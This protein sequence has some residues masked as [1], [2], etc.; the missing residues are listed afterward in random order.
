MCATL[1]RLVLVGIS[2]KTYALQTGGAA[3]SA[4]RSPTAT[5]WR[6][7]GA[8]S[9]GYSKL[10][11]EHYLPMAFVQA[12]ILAS[13]ADI[14]TQ[15]MERHPAPT[16]PLAE[17][18]VPYLQQLHLVAVP[19]APSTPL[20]D[21]LLPLLQSLH[22]IAAPSPLIVAHVLAMATVASTMSGAANAIW[23]RQLESAFPGRATREVAAK[24]LIHAVILASIINSAYLAGVPLLTAFYAD[25]TLP[26]LAHPAAF[27]GGWNLD[28][29]ITLTQLEVRHP[30]P[31]IYIQL[32]WPHTPEM[33]SHAFSRV[34]ISRALQAWRRCLV[35]T[36]TL[37]PLRSFEPSH[38]QICMFIPYNTLAFKFVPPRVRP[39][40]HAMVSAT[41]N[42]A[43]SA[44]TLGYFDV[45][46]ERAAGA[47]A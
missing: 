30:Q 24:T 17:F 43:V 7:I 4:L 11:S 6:P 22:L 46:C 37:E 19:G 36:L 26:S 28:E 21:S 35:P 45:W 42:V 18:V 12:G 47:L 31:S 3:A 25:G 39:L 1:W 8:L 20:A 40:T 41:F 23:L 14:A 32:A 34:H 10:V 2:C 38:G 9:D 5:E 13:G 29:F 33:A 15:V 27:L 16:S 44:V